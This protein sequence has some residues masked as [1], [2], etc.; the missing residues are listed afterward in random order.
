MVYKLSL[1]ISSP[2]E[3][4]NGIFTSGTGL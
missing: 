2:M 3:T 1:I 4:L